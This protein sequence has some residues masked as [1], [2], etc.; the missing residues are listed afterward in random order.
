[1]SQHFPNL[2]SKRFFKPN[3]A[4][5]N[6]RGEIRENISFEDKFEKLTYDEK[7]I[8]FCL[9]NLYITKLLNDCKNIK[10]RI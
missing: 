5:S 9:L 7:N 3:L 2:N 4:P 1:M 10:F 8:L 6:L